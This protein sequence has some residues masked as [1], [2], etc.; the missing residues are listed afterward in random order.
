MRKS[1]KPRFK[2][3]TTCNPCVPVPATVPLRPDELHGLVCQEVQK[4][5]PQI[6]PSYFFDQVQCLT[7]DQVAE[8]TG[9]ARET[10]GDWI[11]AGK[12]IAS[13][14]GKDHLVTV[15]N[16]KTFL[17]AT[18]VQTPVIALHAKFKSKAI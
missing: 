18:R 3:N 15:A 13:K 1:T 12:L 6:L 17:Q 4:A 2:P 10:V 5:L 14:P 8:L 11:R 16:L 9:V 7:T